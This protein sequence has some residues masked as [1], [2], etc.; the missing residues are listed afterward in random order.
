[1]CGGGGGG[2]GAVH[3]GGVSGGP[4]QVMYR[5]EGTSI[6]LFCSL[7]NRKLLVWGR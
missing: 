6:C 1:M 7:I 2:G 4:K 5:L 3:V